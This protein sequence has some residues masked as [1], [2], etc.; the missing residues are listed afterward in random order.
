MKILLALTYYRP[1]TSG[2]TIYAERLAHALAA[3]GHSVTVLTSQYDKALP[4]DEHAGGVRVLRVPVAFRVSKGVIMPAFGAYAWKLVRSHDVLSLHLPQFDASGLA[5]RGRLLKKPVA[6]TYHCDLQL[7]PSLF[8]RVVDKVVFASNVVAAQ[9]AD[10]IVAYTQD[11]AAHSPFLSR[12]LHKV[13]VIPPPVHVPAVTSEEI[14][15]FRTRWNSPIN[16]SSV[17]Q[18]G[19]RQRRAWK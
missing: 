14:A 15:A 18:R 10:T 5:A 12:Y 19:W 11:Y 1:H 17:S 3:R 7:P 8:S 9:F 4:R 13:N 2:L 6:L 16:P